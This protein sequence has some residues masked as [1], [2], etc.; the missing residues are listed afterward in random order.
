MYA[1]DLSKWS[2]NDRFG[3]GSRSHNQKLRMQRREERSQAVREQEPVQLW[4]I[5][6]KWKQQILSA[7]K[8]K[9]EKQKESSEREEG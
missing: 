4:G 5:W 2:F 6:Q 9:E 8:K 1:P 3:M 7:A